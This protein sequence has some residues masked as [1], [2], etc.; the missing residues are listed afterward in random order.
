MWQHTDK[1]KFPGLAG[2]VDGSISHGTAQEFLRVMRGGT[3]PRHD[4][5]SV[6]SLTTR[7]LALRVDYFDRQ[8]HARHADVKV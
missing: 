2:G 1:A 7:A 8:H 6:S 5:G 3:S 4:P